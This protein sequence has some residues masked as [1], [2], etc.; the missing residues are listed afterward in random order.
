MS[1]LGT[2]KFAN[3]FIGCTQYSTLYRTSF[4]DIQLFADRINFAKL[5]QNM[6]RNLRVKK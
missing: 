4:A 6:V 1:Y 3:K 5:L 2:V